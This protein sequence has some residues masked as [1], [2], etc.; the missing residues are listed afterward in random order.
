MEKLK[1]SLAAAS[2][3]LAACKGVEEAELSALEFANVPALCQRILDEGAKFELGNCATAGE[4]DF[5]VDVQTYTSASSGD[6]KINCGYNNTLHGL[7]RRDLSENNRDLCDT[8]ALKTYKGAGIVMRG[9]A[10]TNAYVSKGAENS[11]AL[12][13]YMDS[14]PNSEG[15]TNWNTLGLVDAVNLHSNERGGVSF[16][17]SRESADFPIYQSQYV[18]AV[19][20][21]LKDPD[22]EVGND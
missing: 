16:D 14:D 13:E 6:L 1:S 22:L 10:L 9:F 17:Q 7:D 20:Q 5:I 12:T 4:H 11:E 19:D 3:A 21:L 2:L 18:E 8:Q 15:F